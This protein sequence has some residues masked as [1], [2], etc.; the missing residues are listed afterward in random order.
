M[1]SRAG[2]GLRFTA[3]LGARLWVGIRGRIRKGCS[4][5]IYMM[6]RGRDMAMAR[7]IRVWVW[8]RVVWARASVGVMARGRVI[9]VWI[10]VR[11]MDSL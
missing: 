5:Y 3:M 7:D 6:S 8:V 1:V 11:V 10:R 2:V 9:S 4:K